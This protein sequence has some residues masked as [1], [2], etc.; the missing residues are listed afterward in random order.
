MGHTES[1]GSFP[2]KKVREKLVIF[3]IINFLTMEGNFASISFH[4]FLMSH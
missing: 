2:V 4:N 1:Q 3:M